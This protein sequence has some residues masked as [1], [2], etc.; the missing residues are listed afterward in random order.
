[1]VTT[2]SVLCISQ[3]LAGEIRHCEY[4]STLPPGRHPMTCRR[5][6]DKDD[7]CMAFVTS[8]AMVRDDSKIE[9]VPEDT[10]NTSQ[11]ATLHTGGMVAGSPRPFA[12]YLR[13]LPVTARTFCSRHA[14]LGDDADLAS[15]SSNVQLVTEGAEVND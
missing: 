5:P 11:H 3:N 4:L 1:M 2:V 8:R 6:R 7:I 9:R 13:D 12:S 10:E 15:P 14:R